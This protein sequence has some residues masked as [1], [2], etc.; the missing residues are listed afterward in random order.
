MDCWGIVQ[1][2]ET[3]PAEGATAKEVKD[4]R[5][6]KSRAYSIIYLNTEKTNRPLISDTEDARQAWEKLKQHFR[7]ESRARAVS[8]TVAFFSCRIQE[9]ET[10]RLYAARLRQLV[11]QLK[12]AGAPIAEWYQSFQVIRYLPME[13]SGIVQSIYL[14]EDKKF[15]FDNVVT[16]LLAEESRLKQ[17]QSDLDL[18]VLE[19]KLD[20]TKKV[21][22]NKCVSN[23]CKKYVAKVRKCVGRGK[24]GHVIANCHIK[25]KSN[26]SKEV[27]QNCENSFILEECFNSEIENKSCWVFDTAASTHFSCNLELFSDFKSIENTKMS[28]AVKGVTC[29]IKAVDKNRNNEIV[30]FSISSNDDLE[31]WHRKYC[32]VNPHCIVNTSNNDSVREL[33]NLKSKAIVCEPCRLAK[34]KRRSFKSIGKIRSTKPLELSHLDVCGPLPSNSIQGHCYFLSITDD[35]SRKVTFPTKRRT[36]VY[37]ISEEG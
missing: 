17:C 36:E 13:F 9:G 31:V 22:L 30:G 1:G 4:Y 33:P 23:K 15:I 19:S 11:N 6:R 27:K 8:L 20:R 10:V 5:L 14:W 26:K 12:E 16:E 7:P 29:P 37:K 34:S 24:P 32:H 21:K 3:S 2:T 25:F 35:Y 28:V 18:M